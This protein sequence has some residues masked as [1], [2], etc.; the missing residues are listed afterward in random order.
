MIQKLGACMLAGLLLS[1]PALQAAD[2]QAI[3]AMQEIMAFSAYSGGN[4]LPEQIPA[5]DWAGF[6]VVDARR[7]EDY[8]A[9]HI[10]G[11]V[12]IEWRKVL[13]SIGELPEDRAVIVYCNTGSLSAQAAFA[14]KV[15]TGREDILVLTGGY[16]SWKAKGGFDAHKRASEPRF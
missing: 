12:N 5:A 4:I 3:D 16:D 10:D 11:A 9:S 1:A 2:P 14:L 6:F 15:A 7:P 13:E 8:A